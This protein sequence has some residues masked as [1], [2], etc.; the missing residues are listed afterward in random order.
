MLLT[1]EYETGQITV[2]EFVPTGIHLSADVN[3]YKRILRDQNIFINSVATVVIHGLTE[4]AV[5]QKITYQGQLYHLRRIFLNSDLRNFHQLERTKKVD[6]KGKW[7][8]IY[9]TLQYNEVVECMDKVLPELY[10]QIR[11]EHKL[12]GYEHP[13]CVYQR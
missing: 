3:T 10:K 8:L 2:R 9:K 1:Y 7:F 11:T 4:E 5:K 6:N 13:V 12:E